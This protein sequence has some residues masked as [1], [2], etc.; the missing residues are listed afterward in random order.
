MDRIKKTTGK[1]GGIFR[2]AGTRHGAYS[3]GLT[4]IVIAVVIVFNLRCPEISI[5]SGSIRSSIHRR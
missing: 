3:V 1:I 5:W 4:V 2:T